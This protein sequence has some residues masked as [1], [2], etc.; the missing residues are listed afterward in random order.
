M[1][2]SLFS[3][4]PRP[5]LDA[6]LQS[7]YFREFTPYTISCIHNPTLP[8]CG[9]KCQL[10]LNVVFHPRASRKRTNGLEIFLAVRNT[11]VFVHSPTITDPA[12]SLFFDFSPA[13][14]LT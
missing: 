2:R 13:A 3:G 10:S 6:S 4:V 5:L 14:H 1:T 12:V 7:Y 8:E 9:H 11:L